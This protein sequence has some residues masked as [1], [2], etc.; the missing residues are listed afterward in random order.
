MAGK[1]AADRRNLVT[2]YGLGWKLAETEWSSDRG[3]K[4]R[5]VGERPGKRVANFWFQWGVYALYR[6]QS[7]YRVGISRRLGERL[8]DH[9]NGPHKGK[10]NRFHWFG[11]RE[12]G[13]DKDR[14]GFLHPIPGTKD[15]PVRLTRALHDIEALLERVSPPPGAGRIAYFRRPSGGVEA[16]AGNEGG[17]FSYQCEGEDA[18]A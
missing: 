14:K 5:L 2:S 6:G 7:L 13:T 9:A 4:P 15:S 17:C 8:R 16:D 11:F 12:V 18:I 1:W 3:N 10:W